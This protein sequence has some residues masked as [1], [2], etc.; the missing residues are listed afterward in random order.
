MKL[1]SLLGIAALASL[2]LLPF[3]D[4]SDEFYV[5][6][7]EKVSE[8]NEKWSD[9]IRITYTPGPSS[10]P[11]TYYGND[12]IS[13]VWCEH[14]NGR[15]EIYYK[16][17]S[18]RGKEIVRDMKLSRMS[19][20]ASE[21]S[22]SVDSRGF[23]HVVWL[24][25]DGRFV[26]VLYSKISPG[27]S[28]I[29]GPTVLSCIRVESVYN[30]DFKKTN[31]FENIFR[32][33]GL[34]IFAPSICTD[35]YGCAYIAWVGITDGK[36]KVFYTSIDAT[37][38]V[39]EKKIFIEGQKG[40]SKMPVIRWDGRLVI[41]YVESWEDAERIM[42]WD[43]THKRSVRVIDAEGIESHSMDV[44]SEVHVLFSG[45]FTH[46]EGTFYVESSSDGRVHSFREISK[47]SA[48][49]VD[50]IV[51]NYIHI[52]YLEKFVDSRSSEISSVV[53][54]KCDRNF[55][56]M[57]KKI[58]ICGREILSPSLAVRDKTVVIWCDGRDGLTNS[59]LYMRFS[60]EISIN[61]EKLVY[62]PSNKNNNSFIIAAATFTA[63]FSIIASF[64]GKK[65]FAFSLYPLYTR[66]KKEH[67]LMNPSRKRI[68]DYLM[69]NP[70][71]YFTKIMKELKM[72]NGVLSYHLHTMEKRELVKSEK[73]GSSRRYY[74][75]NHIP[76]KESHVIVLDTIKSSPG[77]SVQ[78]IVS[79]TD[80]PVLKVKKCIHD[81]ELCGKIYSKRKGKTD[82]FFAY[83]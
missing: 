3:I 65:I 44:N 24:E 28:V 34:D 31:W 67:I 16:K 26:M 64:K 51:E 81:L 54:M 58:V 75:V 27:G 14:T 79:R 80:I 19:V 42:L 39:N 63:L 50:I 71:A 73:D 12:G 56:D 22:V 35:K 68:Y 77:C 7:I 21:P 11:S 60:H 36:T 33:R 57:E 32:N 55:T 83:D 5:P 49:S 48:N 15:G 40:Y 41:T 72:K 25:L 17:V 61:D 62:I 30:E 82:R 43:S 69:Q 46:S 66:I 23:A 29:V 59:E 38:K 2:L 1:L 13:V 9:D 10:K 37:G 52:A 47:Y 45:K 18:Y 8:K 74:A 53:Y 76:I 4:I 6:V 20:S 70:G 78:D